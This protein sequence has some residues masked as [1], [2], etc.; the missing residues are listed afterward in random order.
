MWTRQVKH[1]C[2]A[3]DSFTRRIAKTWNTR[4]G[5]MYGEIA[6]LTVPRVAS[7]S[8]QVP[9]QNA[10]AF[11]N[12]ALATNSTSFNSP[13]QSFNVLCD[14]RLVKVLA[15]R[16]TR[17]GILPLN[18]KE[19]L[20]SQ[21]CSTRRDFPQLMTPRALDELGE[22]LRRLQ[23]N[24]EVVSLDR[25]LRRSA[26]LP[27]PMCFSSGAISYHSVLLLRGLLSAQK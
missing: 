19:R 9:R 17:R 16:G 23:R 6:L 13:N 24:V 25:P 4:K 3:V 1:P 15:I 20:G 21:E 26:R 27:P 12:S 11:A 8:S 2:R 14:T 10:S 22:T 18:R 5:D 7:S